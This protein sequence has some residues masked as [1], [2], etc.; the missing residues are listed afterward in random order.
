MIDFLKILI[1]DK[2]LIESIWRNK[3]LIY[4][5][6]DKRLI[7][8][9]GEIKKKEVKK[10]KNLL[11][12]KYDNKLEITGSVHYY[13]NEGIH[14]ANDFTVSD[15][16]AIIN[17][18]KIDLNLD[19]S[20]CR[21]INLEYGI[22]IL[23]PFSVKKVVQGLKYHERN[24]YRYTKN[25]KY[26]KESSS[27]TKDG[28]V[29]TYKTIKSYAKGLQLFNGET[30]ADEN[31]FRFEVKSKRSKY[32][33]TLGINTLQDLTNKDVYKRMSS[34]LVKEWS[35]VLLLDK[36]TDFK[37]DKRTRKYINSDFWEDIL[38]QSRN[39]FSYH[40]RNYSKLLSKYP[41]NIVEAIRV[42]IESK[43]S[44]IS[45]P[46]AKGGLVQ[47]LEYICGNYAQKIE[48]PCLVTGLDISM[49]RENSFIL[50]HSG[51]YYYQ[52]H[53]PKIFE[54]LKLKYL[55]EYWGEPDLKKQIKEIYHNI[56]NAKNNAEI[57]Q[58]RIYPA[59][60]YRLFNVG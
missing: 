3:L 35:N 13:F 38:N 15:C 34:E 48:K 44:A 7:K 46:I 39:S 31:T 33:N 25:L 55:T 22:N 10:L 45:T 23:L 47:Y 50:S 32:I 52:K 21:I 18:I 14:N 54:A 57:K 30:M 43:I 6:E 17:S 36:I 42:L 27:F 28:R 24:E 51:L 60:N 19:L 20:K 5:N 16:I 59:D 9:S 53:Y 40:K 4:S 41:N 49:Q 56:R 11:F 37:A 12:T 1:L 58:R 29:N 26:S 8:E 2:I